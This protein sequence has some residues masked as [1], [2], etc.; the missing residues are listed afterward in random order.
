MDNGAD[1]TIK[2][3]KGKTP[4]DIAKEKGNKEVLSHLEGDKKEKEA[5]EKIKK[6]VDNGGGLEDFIK[7]GGNVIKKIVIQEIFLWQKL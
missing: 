4:L 1:P 6:V 2:D 5:N 3:E 7:S